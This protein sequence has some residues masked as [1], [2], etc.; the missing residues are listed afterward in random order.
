MVLITALLLLAAF[1][2]CVLL[3]PLG[4]DIN[5]YKGRGHTFAF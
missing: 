1:L 5:S 2:I 3:M 4:L